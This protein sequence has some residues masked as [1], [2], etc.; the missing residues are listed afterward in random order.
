M[1]TYESYTM[2]DEKYLFSAINYLE[3]KVKMFRDAHR[4]YYTALMIV[5]TT[6]NKLEKLQD[7]LND[8]HFEM[9]LAFDYFKGS[10]LD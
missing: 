9:M 6:E 3:E 8:A 10:K 7:K 5:E 4:E 2:E 1:K